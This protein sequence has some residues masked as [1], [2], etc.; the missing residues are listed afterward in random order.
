MKPLRKC[1]DCGIEAR[2]EKELENFRTSRNSKHGKDNHCKNC[3]RKENKV[4]WKT[5]KGRAVRLKRYGITPQE[6]DDMYYKQLGR[7]KICNTHASELQDAKTFLSVDHCHTTGQ[8]RGLLCDSCNL[9]LGK[10]YDDINNLKKAIDYLMEH[11][12]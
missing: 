9:G 10:F 4:Y 11:S 1:R 3:H 2:S 12:K 5:D 6:Y 8:V 7:C